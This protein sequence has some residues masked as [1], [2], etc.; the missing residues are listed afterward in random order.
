MLFPV[1]TPAQHYQIF[2]FILDITASALT[3]KWFLVV[4]V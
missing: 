4:N 1:A 3:V 2:G